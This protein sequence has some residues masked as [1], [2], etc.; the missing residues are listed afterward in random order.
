MAENK[1]L[2]KLGQSE[3]GSIVDRGQEI[4]IDLQLDDNIIADTGTV[5]GKTLDGDG[6]PISDVTIKITDTEYN[7]KYHTL[8]HA[9]GEFTIDNVKAGEQYLI[10]A[11][12]DKYTLKQ[13]TPFVMQ[14]SQ[15]VERNFVMTLDNGSANSLVAGDVLNEKGDKVEGVTVRLYNNSG[16]EPVLLKTTHTNQFGQYAFFDIAQGMYILEISLLGYKT[17]E[18]TFVISETDKVMNINL[19]MLNDPIGRQ[20]TINGVINDKDGI[21]VEGAFVVLFKVETDGEEKEKLVPIRKTI[22][23]DEGV[24][25]FEQVPEGNYKIKSNKL[26]P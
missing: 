6:N 17:T 3:T 21:L 12:K 7:P 2:Y 24:Y 26:A 9:E 22:T 5:F 8:T 11:V 1:D 16:A 19:T 13:G 4:R 23:N 18:T 14:K 20:G 25:L 15:Q 10:L